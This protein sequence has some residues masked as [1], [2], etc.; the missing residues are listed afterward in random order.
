M[1]QEKGLHRMQVASIGECMVEL[2]AR[3][4]GLYALRFG[5]D[6]LNTATYLARLGIDTGYMTALGDDPYSDAMLAQWRE[7]GIACDAV[8]RLAGRMPGL[9]MIETD[10]TG[11]R[12]FY[13]WRE[14]AP[15]REWITL[16][17]EALE[18]ALMGC[19][20]V[21]FSGITLSLYGEGGRASF[22]AL[23]ARLKA[24]GVR[25]AFDGNYRPR[26]WAG[27][28][29]AGA[30]F[31]AIL[32]LLDLALPTLEDEQAIYGDADAEACATRLLAA[33]VGEVAVKQGARGVLSATRQGRRFIA[34]SAPLQPVDTTAAG[35]SFNAGYLAAR[36]RGLGPAAA[37]RAGHLVAGAVILRHG[38]IIPKDSMPNINWTDLG[39]QA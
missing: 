20:W 1:L 8:R 11:E 39:E 4:E 15:A 35:D 14:R 36:L 29:A 31:A 38:A 25:L 18:R 37:A 22:L 28:A 19:Q 13:Y 32:P 3:G 34:P 12:R 10:A 21:Y 7:E 27:P 26:G 9:Y 23:L 16:L 2:G 5:G 33:G 17:D 6:T 24:A 30:A